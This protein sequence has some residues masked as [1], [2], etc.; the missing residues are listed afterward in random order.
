MDA[1]AVPVL[2]GDGRYVGTVTEGDLL[3][4]MMDDAG[5]DLEKAELIFLKDM[6]RRRDNR[7]VTVN[8][9]MDDLVDVIKDQNFVPVIDDE[10]RFIGIVTRKDVI[11]FYYREYQKAEH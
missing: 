1:T 8:T 7:P 4:A 3:W 9:D 6:K 2:T 11:G 10:Q 5:F